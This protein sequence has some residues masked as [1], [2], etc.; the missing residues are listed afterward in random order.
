VP[1]VFGQLAVRSAGV[2]RLV[3]D[4]V[5]SV[6]AITSRAKALAWLAGA[7]Q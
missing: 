4:E 1:E 6:S 3:L 2:D 7:A 5:P